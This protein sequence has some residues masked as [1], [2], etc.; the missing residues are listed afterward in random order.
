MFARKVFLALILALLVITPLAG[1]SSKELPTNHKKEFKVRKKIKPVFYCPL[2]GVKVD[3]EGQ[4]RR[5][6]LVIKVEN[7]PAARPQSGLS[8]ACL[9]YE[10]P[11]EGFITRFNVVYLH[12]E[13]ETV[14]PVRS[15]RLSDLEILSQYQGVLVFSGASKR[16]MRE[17]RASPF[18]LLDHG[19]HEELFWRS[20]YR[21][22]PH[23]LYT[24]TRKIRDYLD[25]KKMGKRVEYQGFLFKDDTPA[26]TLT[27]TNLK[28]DFSS[29]CR[30]R[31][32][33]DSKTN[34]YFRY[35]SSK[36]SV[37]ALSGKKLRAKN[38]IFFFAK[39]N[40]SGLRD[41]KGSR[42]PDFSLTGQGKALV[43][44]DGK[45]IPAKWFSKAGTPFFLNDKGERLL[46]NRGLTW[47]EVIPSNGSIPWSYK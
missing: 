21:R 7:S 14:G 1:C 13:S 8:Q 34:C 6:S 22:M 15:G 45:V 20:R 27:A 17:L 23:N 42:S 5:S 18:L 40:W 26:T 25:R 19:G 4:L 43:F 2:C 11:V 36:V 32:I 41:K 30:A 47:I 29:V 33:Y 16:V 10:F 3:H 35:Q 46:F 31:F 9:I 38:V 24:N 37:D 39:L 44:I 12:G 28:V